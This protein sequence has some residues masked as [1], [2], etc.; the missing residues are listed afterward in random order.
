MFAVKSLDG[1]GNSLFPLNRICPEQVV[2]P[3]NP[4]SRELIISSIS[5]GPKNVNLDKMNSDPVIMGRLFLLFSI[6]RRDTENSG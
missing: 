5:S 1:K 2:L 4:L 6:F 3:V